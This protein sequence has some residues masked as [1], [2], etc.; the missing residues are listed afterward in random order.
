MND[1][2]GGVCWWSELMRLRKRTMELRTILGIVT[3]DCRASDVTELGEK[4]G[5][6]RWDQRTETGLRGRLRDN[7]DILTS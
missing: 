7:W 1:L 4:V 6:L 5:G 2:M 3:W